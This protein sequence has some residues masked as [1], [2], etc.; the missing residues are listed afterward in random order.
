MELIYVCS[1]ETWDMLRQPFADAEYILDIYCKDSDRLYVPTIADEANME[2]ARDAAPASRTS[3][4]RSCATVYWTSEEVPLCAGYETDT[5][6]PLVTPEFGPLGS[7]L[8]IVEP[9]DLAFEGKS[10]IV[11]IL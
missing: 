1:G 4:S 8:G 5:D 6:T 11:C 2:P 10:K 3:Q 9:F 7:E